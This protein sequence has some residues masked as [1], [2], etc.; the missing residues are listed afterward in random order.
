MTDINKCIQC[1]KSTK[2]MLKVLLSKDY[3]VTKS[4]TKIKQ[5]NRGFTL[6]FHEK[7]SSVKTRASYIIV[8]VTCIPKKKSLFT[9]STVLLLSPPFK[10][11]T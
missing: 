9:L 10:L 2:I 7:L 6:H 3:K 5:K 1:N 4:V 11:S 8:K